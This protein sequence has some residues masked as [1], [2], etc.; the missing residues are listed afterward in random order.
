MCECVSIFIYMYMYTS[1]FIYWEKYLF[2]LVFNS[3]ENGK[4]GTNLIENNNLER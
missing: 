1:V 2:N 4:E 3:L